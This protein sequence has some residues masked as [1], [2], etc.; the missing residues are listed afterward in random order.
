[1]QTPYLNDLVKEGI[2][3]DRHYVFKFCAP[4]RAAAQVG[5]NPIHVNTVN[6]DPNNYNPHDPVSGYSGVPRNMT[7]VAEV[8]KKA[9]YATHFAGKWDCGMA[10][11]RHTPRGRGYDTS[12]HYFHHMEDYWQNWFQ[13]G[14]GAWIVYKPVAG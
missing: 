3:L 13:N 8:M 10:T 9:G 2:E 7:G 1:M 14:N 11:P 12:L 5:R 4:T 6:N